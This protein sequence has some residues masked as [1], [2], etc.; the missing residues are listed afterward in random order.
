MY[1]IME[2]WNM[3]LGYTNIRKTMQFIKISHMH[4]HLHKWTTSRN[5]HHIHTS[6]MMKIGEEPGLKVEHFP[7]IQNVQ[8]SMRSQTSCRSTHKAIYSSEKLH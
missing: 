7:E 3:W 8:L 6:E 1:V 2:L 5:S 4:Q